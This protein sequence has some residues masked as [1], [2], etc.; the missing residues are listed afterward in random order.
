[1][2]ANF[3]SITRAAAGAARN[4]TRYDLVARIEDLIAEYNAGSVNIDEYLRRLV[5]LSKTLSKEEQRA[6]AED[7]TEEELAIF[8]LLTKPDPVL[9]DDERALV[10]ASAKQLLSHLHDKLVL[11]WRRRAATTADVRVTILDVLDERLPEDPYPP[12]VFDAK[13]QAVFDHVLTAY[14]DDLSLPAARVQPRWRLLPQKP[15]QEPA[16]LPKRPAG[17]SGVAETESSGR[18]QSG[19]RTRG[20]EC[21]D[22]PPSMRCGSRRKGLEGRQTRDELAT[23]SGCP[24][25]LMAGSTNAIAL[26][27]M[28]PSGYDSSEPAALDLVHVQWQARA[29][30]PRVGA[31]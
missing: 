20:S 3:S 9:T 31:E 23:D 21:D 13:V 11:D 7:L 16:V 14:G 8:D 27:L 30:L 1:V 2:P 12:E 28:D 10:R 29:P 15:L 6:V 5:E 19:R 4:P 22:S 24:E 26:V 17:A 25:P 18:R